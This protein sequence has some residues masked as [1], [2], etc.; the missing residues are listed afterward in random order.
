MQLRV[1]G[2]ESHVID[3]EQSA[4]RRM[5][6][7]LLTTDDF[8][9]LSAS[10]QVDLAAR[11]NRGRVRPYNEDHFLLLRL[12][13]SQEIVA[14][15]LPDGEVP[16]R[17][18]EYGHGLV[19]ADG[20]GTNGA[21]SV[22]ARVALSTLAHM[23]IHYGKWN[24]RVDPKT[25][26]DVLARFTWLYNRADEAVVSARVTKGLGDVATAVTGAYCAGDDLF[27]AHVGHSRAYL[28][29]DGRLTRLTRDHTTAQYLA[30]TGRPIAVERRGQDLSHIL[31]DAIG[32]R[33]D[34]PVVEVEHFKLTNG[35]CLLLCTNGLSDMV[36]DTRIADVLS[37]R[38]RSVEQCEALIDL[39]LEAGGEDN[40]TVAL[41][42]F[43]IPTPPPD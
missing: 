26:E 33:G 42:Q 2:A 23:V 20:L 37:L 43:R 1:P 6:S 31:T 11:S 5:L 39:A 27:I 4:R 10:V 35:D 15:S 22:A 38:R 18:D 19:I 3:D 32:A 36:A 9:P 25:A 13:R 8:L 21:G 30:D 40:V 34:Q 41:G 17:F 29:N 12:G 7:P 14:T 24:V 16:D 28:F